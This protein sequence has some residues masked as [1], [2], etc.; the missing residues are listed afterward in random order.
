MQTAFIQTVEILVFV[1]IALQKEAKFVV[2][3]E[4]PT[5]IR[6]NF[7]S[8]PARKTST[9]QLFHRVNVHQVCLKQCVSIILVSS[10][11]VAKGTPPFSLSRLSLGPRKKGTLKTQK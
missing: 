8:T 5:T 10:F 7:K 11:L 4:E 3:M 2:Q 9:F 6:A 1:L